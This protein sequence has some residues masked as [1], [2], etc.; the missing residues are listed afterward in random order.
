MGLKLGDT[1]P[2]FTADSSQGQIHWHEYID[3]S[4]AILVSSVLSDPFAC[5][6]VSNKCKGN[7]FIL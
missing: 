4:W 5:F 2:D 1:F 3:G 7:V 6:I